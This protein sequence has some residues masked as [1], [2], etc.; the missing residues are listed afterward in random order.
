MMIVRAASHKFI[1]RSETLQN[2]SSLLLAISILDARFTTNISH[3]TV[4]NF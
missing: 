3:C 1:L 2:S 4:V